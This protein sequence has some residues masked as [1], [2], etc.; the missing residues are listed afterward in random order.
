MWL[1]SFSEEEVR[2]N[3]FKGTYSREP[4][5]CTYVCYWI[6]WKHYKHSNITNTLRYYTCLWFRK[7]KQ[8]LIFRSTMKISFFKT[9]PFNA[10][11][12]LCYHG[13]RLTTVS[14]SVWQLHACR[15]RREAKVTCLDFRDELCSPKINFLSGSNLRSQDCFKDKINKNNLMHFLNDL[16]IY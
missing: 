7:S 10:F 1:F 4:K 9:M 16:Q 14:I 11:M 12:Q 6:T 8:I 2:L 3:K 5:V 15:G 13:K